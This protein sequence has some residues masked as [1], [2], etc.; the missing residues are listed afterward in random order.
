MPRKRKL[1]AK[2]HTLWISDDLWKFVESR[3]QLT[4]QSAASVVEEAIVFFRDQPE[5]LS[6]TMLGDLRRVIADSH[7][8][9]IRFLSSRPGSPKHRGKLT[10]DSVR[11]LLGDGLMR[12]I[13]LIASANLKEM[14]QHLE[15]RFGPDPSPEDMANEYLIHVMLTLFF[16]ADKPKSTAGKMFSQKSLDIQKLTAA[17]LLHVAQEVLPM[18]DSELSPLR[19]S[20]HVD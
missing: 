1:K 6:N 7:T 13:G 18:A 20:V 10:L 15:S 5:R 4:Q 3:Q 19:R 8:T 14:G 11:E 17:R 16:L 9:M 2:G 12:Y